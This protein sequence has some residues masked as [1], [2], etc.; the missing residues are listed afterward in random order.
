FRHFPSSHVVDLSVGTNTNW[1]CTSVN[2][3]LNRRSFIARTAVAAAAAITMPADM[4]ASSF[5]NIPIGYT[6]ITW[7]N[8]QVEDAIATVAKLG[9]YGF[10]TFGDVL[11]QWEGKGGLAPVLEKNHLP[12]ISGYC[13]LNLTDASRRQETMG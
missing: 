9:F 7:P 4:F 5:S 10:E 3:V 8:S 12:L 2:S 6:G 11:T 1:E 13:T